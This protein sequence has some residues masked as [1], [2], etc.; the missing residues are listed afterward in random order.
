MLL[1]FAGKYSYPGQLDASALE[2]RDIQVINKSGNRLVLKTGRNLLVGI[3]EIHLTENNTQA[4]I[5]M[6]SRLLFLLT[7]PILIIGSAI[8]EFDGAIINAVLAALALLFIIS[9]LMGGFVYVAVESA[10]ARL[11]EAIKEALVS[12]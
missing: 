8:G 11:D 2:Q 10:K 3:A 9:A 12:S 6:S 7:I 4:K 5:G 1:L